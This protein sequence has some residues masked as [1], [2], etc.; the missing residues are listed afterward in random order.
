MGLQL[1][2][3]QVLKNRLESDDQPKLSMKLFD[4]FVPLPPAGTKLSPEQL[5]A[6]FGGDMRALQD[7]ARLAYQS[8]DGEAE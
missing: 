6:V 3:E 1:Q 8:D 7:L 4:T 2:D 5:D